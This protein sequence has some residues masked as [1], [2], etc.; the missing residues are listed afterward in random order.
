MNKNDKRYI[1]ASIAIKDT[2]LLILVEKELNE[3]KVKEITERANINRST[4][5]S[6]YQD[7]YD[8]YRDIENDIFTEVQKLVANDKDLNMQQRY[9]LL[10]DSIKENRT[11]CHMI[12]AENSHNNLYKKLESAF[13]EVVQSNSLYDEYYDRFRISGTLAMIKHWVNTDYEMPQ[14][15]LETMIANV[16]GAVEYVI[17][18]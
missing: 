5:Y 16:V 2:F 6:H 12:F 9:Q 14:E 8:L 17:H 18:N 13:L 1:K 4:F 11:Y 10:L 7:V 15:E 3:I